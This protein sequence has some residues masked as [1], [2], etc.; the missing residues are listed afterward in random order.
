MLISIFQLDIILLHK[1]KDKE[2]ANKLTPT[3]LQH[4]SRAQFIVRQS[5]LTV[6]YFVSA[7]KEVPS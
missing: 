5:L 6:S 4:P 2:T 3:F 7:K 1:P